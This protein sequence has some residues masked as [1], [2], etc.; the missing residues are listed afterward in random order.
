MRKLRSLLNLG[1]RVQQRSYAPAGARW[2]NPEELT[3][4]KVQY[5]AS[6]YFSHHISWLLYIF[7]QHHQAVA[8]NSMLISLL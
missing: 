6:A 2:F 1:G 5:L 7:Q 3:A 8:A 4:Q